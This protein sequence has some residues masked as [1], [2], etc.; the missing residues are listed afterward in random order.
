[1]QS[2]LCRPFFFEFDWNV[3]N[4]NKKSLYR[5]IQWFSIVVNLVLGF[6]FESF[7]HFYG[8]LFYDQNTTFSNWFIVRRRKFLYSNIG[9]CLG[10][11]PKKKLHTKSDW[12]NNDKQVPGFMWTD[13]HFFFCWISNNVMDWWSVA[14]LKNLEIHIIDRRPQ[15]E[16]Y[17][18]MNG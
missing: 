11:P 13:C 16:F 7:S 3:E 12:L 2:S 8:L 18:N 14:S 4:V 17:M 9:C 5:H 6:F 1:M 15:I 10:E